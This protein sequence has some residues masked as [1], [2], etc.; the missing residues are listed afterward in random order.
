MPNDF[1]VIP[2]EGGPRTGGLPDA[3]TLA[4]LV[5]NVTEVVSATRFVPA[6]DSARG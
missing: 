4:R 5:S 3:A 2:L 6:D 1:V